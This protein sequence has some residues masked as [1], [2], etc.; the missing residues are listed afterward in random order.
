MGM[1]VGTDGMPH[2]HSGA[3]ILLS[4]ECHYVHMMVPNA[5]YRTGKF[6]TEEKPLTLKLWQFVNINIYHTSTAT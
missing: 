5:F 4:F 6:H 3:Q 1:G 2:W